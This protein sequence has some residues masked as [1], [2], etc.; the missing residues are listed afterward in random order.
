[1]L[2][3]LE[4]LNPFG[5]DARLRFSKPSDNSVLLVSYPDTEYGESMFRELQTLSR[6][7]DIQSKAIAIEVQIECGGRGGSDTKLAPKP[8][9]SLFGRTTDNNT[10]HFKLTSGGSQTMSNRTVIDTCTMDINI[11]PAINGNNTLYLDAATP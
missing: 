11:K 8:L 2:P 9:L 3:Q 1:V 6:V 10:A 5:P 7:A 4:A